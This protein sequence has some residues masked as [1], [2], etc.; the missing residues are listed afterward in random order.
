[1]IAREWTHENETGAMRF[2]RSM[3]RTRV[4]EIVRFSFLVFSQ[5]YTAMPALPWLELE[6]TRKRLVEK[7]TGL[8][9]TNDRFSGSCSCEAEIVPV[10]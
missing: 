5:A 6:L 1:M 10:P 9:F 4:Q 7:H 2:I 8:V 3:E